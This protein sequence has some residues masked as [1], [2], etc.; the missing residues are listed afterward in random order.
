MI[1]LGGSLCVKRNQRHKSKKEK[2]QAAGNEARTTTGYHFFCCELG[3]DVFSD[4]LEGKGEGGWRCTYK[5]A[6][7]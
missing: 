6:Y 4:E 2:T 5:H 3:S 7:I 1:L